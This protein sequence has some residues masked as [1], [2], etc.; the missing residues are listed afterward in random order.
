M[1]ILV[2]DKSQLCVDGPQVVVEA[3]NWD[4]RVRVELDQ[5]GSSLVILATARLLLLL[6]L[7]VS[8]HVW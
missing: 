3:L 7:E 8:S 4:G 2:V 5:R 1:A 6:R